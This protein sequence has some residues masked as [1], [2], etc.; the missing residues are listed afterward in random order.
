MSALSNMP[1]LQLVH[2]SGLPAEQVR[3][4]ELHTM[5]VPSI[6][7]AAY[8]HSKHESPFEHLLHRGIQ[9]TALLLAFK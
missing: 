9:G 7:V 2:S 3:Q 5:Q 8:S 6:R 1:I 4:L